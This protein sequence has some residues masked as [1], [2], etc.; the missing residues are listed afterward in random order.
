MALEKVTYKDQ[1][2]VITAK[3]LNDIQDAVI[4][5]QQAVEELQAQ[6]S[7]PASSFVEATVE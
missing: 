5:N 6:T 4:A 2:T 3:N 1:V 7:T